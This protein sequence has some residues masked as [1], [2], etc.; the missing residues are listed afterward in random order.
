[1]RR[2][3]NRRD[4]IATAATATASLAFAACGRNPSQAAAA[5]STASASA[6][7]LPGGFIALRRNV[8]IFNARGGTIG[9]LASADSLAIVDT[10]YPDTAAKCLAGLPQRGS[11][12]IDAVINTH[13]HT[14]HSSGNPVFRPVAKTIVAQANVPA[15]QRAAAERAKPPVTD[16]QVYA[17]TTFPDTWKLALADETIHARYFGPAHTA[18]DIIVLFEKANVVHMG[19]LIFNR[20]HAAIDRI[21]GAS[22]ANWITVL[23]TAAKTYP[24]DALY[25]FGH[26][27]TAPRFGVTGKRD[28]LLVMRDYLGALLDHTRRQIAAGKSRAEIITLEDLPGFPDFHQPHPNRFASNLGHA[29]DELTNAPRG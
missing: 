1:M 29:Y 2:P 20:I 14:D 16:K 10:Q 19:D 23:E 7:P 6:A 22:I 21:G 11:R 4:F 28:D 13:H 12:R 26:G 15:L 8:G 25:V 17:D 3:I 24:A 5:S 27:N 9:W 18:G